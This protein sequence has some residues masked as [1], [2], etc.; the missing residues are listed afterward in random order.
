MVWGLGWDQGLERGVQ[1]GITM[2]ASLCLTGRGFEHQGLTIDSLVRWTATRR[3]A[4]SSTLLQDPTTYSKQAFF[5]YTLNSK[6]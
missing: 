4:M 6:P 3:V 5:P 2:S 1:E